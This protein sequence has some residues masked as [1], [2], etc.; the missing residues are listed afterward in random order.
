MRLFLNTLSAKEQ[1][2][3]RRLEE[4]FLKFIPRFEKN[5]QDQQEYFHRKAVF[6]EN[7]VKI[8]QHDPEKEGF[9]IDVNRFTDWTQEEFD[10]IFATKFLN[11]EPEDL[12]LSVDPF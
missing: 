5:Y 11:M 2:L 8:M 9:S 1:M 3:D 7:Y 6:Q 10:G 4:A 12:K